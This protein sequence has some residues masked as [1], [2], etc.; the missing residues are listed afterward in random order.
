M[1]S[2]SAASVPALTGIQRLPTT[3]AVFRPKRIHRNRT[4]TRMVLQFA[5]FSDALMKRRCPVDIVGNQGIASPKDNA[6]GLF[7]DDRPN[8][9]LKEFPADGIRKDGRNCCGGVAVAGLNPSAQ[10][11]RAAAAS[12]QWR[13]SPNRLTSIHS[14]GPRRPKDRKSHKCAA[15]RQP[16]NLKPCPMKQVRIH[17]HRARHERLT[18]FPN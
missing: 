10:N 17:P 8:G 14:C 7:L 11:E 15:I 6:L 18:P 9:G 4:D 13:C 5:D 3:S 16:L 2:I 1:P 12:A